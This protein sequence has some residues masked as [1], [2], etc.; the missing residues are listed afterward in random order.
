MPGLWGEV[1]EKQVRPP[2]HHWWFWAIAVAIILL[3]VF[4]PRTAKEPPRENAL[5]PDAG[6]GSEVTTA[7][8]P[9]QTGPEAPVDS[10]VPAESGENDSALLNG[11]AMNAWYSGDLRTAMTLFEQAIAT[12]PD[13]PV[14]HTNYGRLLTLMVALDRAI[15]LLERA[16]DLEPQNVQAWLDLATVYERAQLFSKSWEAQA[17]A[18]KLVGADSITRDEQ[19]RFILSGTSLSE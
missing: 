17:E 19:G 11:Q 6:V 9:V 13:D 12:A 14:P 15:P 7:V 18:A 1:V 5:A 16:R 2:A 4:W 8:E 3:I 10:D